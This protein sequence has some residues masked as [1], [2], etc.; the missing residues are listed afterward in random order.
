MPKLDSNSDVDHQV[1]MFE[2]TLEEDNITF[3][4]HTIEGLKQYRLEIGEEKYQLVDVIGDDWDK[5]SI[6]Q[7]LIDFIEA[8]PPIGVSPDEIEV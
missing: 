6:P 7:F 2:I 3:M 1:T 5:E 8:Y 4:L